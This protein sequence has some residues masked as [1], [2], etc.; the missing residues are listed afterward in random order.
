MVCQYLQGGCR[1]EGDRHFSRIRGDRTRGNGFRLKEGRFR[2][3][4]RRKFYTIRVVRQWHRLPGEV[5]D[6]PSLETV[7]ITLDRALSNLI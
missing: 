3:D 4:I 1:K 2:L 7:K 6:V 5:V